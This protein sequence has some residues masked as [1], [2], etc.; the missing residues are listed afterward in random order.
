L[1]SRS[2]YQQP[3]V[4]KVNSTLRRFND[5][6]RRGIS[7]P[8]LFGFARDARRGRRKIYGTFGRSQS[9]LRKRLVKVNSDDHRSSSEWAMDVVM[10]LIFAGG[11]MCGVAAGVA[12]RDP[13]EFAISRR[14]TDGWTPA[15]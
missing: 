13:H 4:R 15:G 14:L 9:G 1:T 12:G 3:L 10:R 2:V 6:R 7:A 8:F 11:V 5:C